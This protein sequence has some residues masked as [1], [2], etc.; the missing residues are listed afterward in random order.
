[1]ELVSRLIRKNVW[2]N[3]LAITDTY[4]IYYN[5]MYTYLKKKK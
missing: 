5:K 4:Q 1:M 2:N 3:V